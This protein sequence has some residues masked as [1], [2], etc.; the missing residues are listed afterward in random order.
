MITPGRIYVNTSARFTIAFRDDDGDLVD[1]T[2]VTFRTCDPCGN[3]VD[4]VYLTDSEITKLATGRYA[5][6]IEPDTSGRYRAGWVTTGA[7]TVFATEFDFLVQESPWSA[8]V[9]G[10][11]DYA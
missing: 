7:G 6:D 3:K 5:A 4:Y 1:P 2:T 9:F 10:C 8:D 11:C